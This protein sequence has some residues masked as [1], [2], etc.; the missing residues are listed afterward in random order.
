MGCLVGY[1]GHWLHP[2]RP[3]GVITEQHGTNRP[4]QATGPSKVPPVVRIGA[5]LPFPVTA[6]PSR[7]TTLTCK[8][9][10][11][12][13]GAT[14]GQVEGTTHGG[15]EEEELMALLSRLPPPPIHPPQRPKAAPVPDTASTNTTKQLKLWTNMEE[16]VKLFGTQVRL[17]VSCFLLCC[18]SAV[19]KIQMTRF[20]ARRVCL[21]SAQ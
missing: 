7:G 10:F 18:C 12:K 6:A 3:D 11:C 1:S 21:V 19:I 16:R 9:G 20:G 14:L 5:F 4:Q 8:D 2:G 17:A 13:L 15:G